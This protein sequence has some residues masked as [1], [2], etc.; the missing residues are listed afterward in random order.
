MYTHANHQGSLLFFS[1]PSNEEAGSGEACSLPKD[2]HSGGGTTRTGPLIL[3]SIHFSLL[4]QASMTTGIHQSQLITG[5][6]WGEG[7]FTE[8]RFWGSIQASRSKL[9]E[10]GCDGF[11]EKLPGGA[12]EKDLTGESPM[13]SPATLG[14]MAAYRE[15]LGVT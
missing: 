13:G 15:V 7:F 12:G 2:T 5:C 11:Q 10:I 1:P 3:C 14:K 9:A 6:V 4:G 8:Y